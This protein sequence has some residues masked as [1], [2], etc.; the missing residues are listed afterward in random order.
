M[1]E[2]CVDVNA[3]VELPEDCRI[4][5]R[6]D[7]REELQ[8]SLGDRGIEVRFPVEFTVEAIHPVKRVCITSV[9]LDPAAVKDLSGAPSLVLRRLGKQESAWDLAKRYHTTIGAILSAN[10]LEQESELPRDQLL[11][12][13]RKR[14]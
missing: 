2:R 12:I 11:L 1:A 5:V 13:P 4:S 7:C 9:K 8:S 10:Q 6:A 3:Q 14:T